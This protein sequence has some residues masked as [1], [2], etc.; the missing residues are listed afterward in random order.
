[1][2]TVLGMVV[3]LDRWIAKLSVAAPTT[4]RT[5]ERPG[6]VYT[7]FPKLP[8]FH[9]ELQRGLFHLSEALRPLVE[10]LVQHSFRR[11]FYHSL[12]DTVERRLN[13]PERLQFDDH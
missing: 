1:M 4:R 2:F 13:F 8:E 3:S 11:M 10:E 5:R 12:M 7:H 9:D 6:Q